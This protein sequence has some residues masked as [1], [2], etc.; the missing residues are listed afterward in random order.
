MTARLNDSSS[1]PWF[2]APSPKKGAATRSSP[3]ALNVYAAPQAI[4]T[5]A[6]TI[7]FAP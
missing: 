3:R 6:P 2:M 5:P 1:T 7:P 4:G